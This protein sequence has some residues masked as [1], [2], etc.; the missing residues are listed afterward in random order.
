MPHFILILPDEFL[1]DC[2]ELIGGDAGIGLENILLDFGREFAEVGD[3][4][5]SGALPAHNFDKRR[6]FIRI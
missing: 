4:A 6:S 3:L 1:V 5:D 2:A